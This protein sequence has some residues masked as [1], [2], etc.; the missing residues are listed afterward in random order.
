MIWEPR[1]LPEVNPETEPYWKGAADGKLLIGECQS[2]EF[3]FHYPRAF[4]PDCF[5]DD[6]SLVEA[7]GTGTVYTY[8]GVRKMSGWPEEDLPLVVGYVELDEGVRMMTNIRNAHPD[9]V[10][11]GDKVRVVFVP[12][13]NEDIA[14]P[15]FELVG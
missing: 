1:P 2:C 8:A 15:V 12:T 13:E 10:E 5:S 6:V 3:Q 7:A 4:C 11:V 9:D 14:I